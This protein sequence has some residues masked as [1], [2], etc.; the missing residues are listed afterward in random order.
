MNPHLMS[1]GDSTSSLN[2][3]LSTALDSLVA[4]RLSR[5]SRPEIVRV[6]SAIPTRSLTVWEKSMLATMGRLRMEEADPA[7]LSLYPVTSALSN[8]VSRM[9]SLPLAELENERMVSLFYISV[10]HCLLILVSS[11]ATRKLR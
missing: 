3:L 9:L 7:M 2:S 11:S 10:H 1:R 5:S 8:L 4:L 6:I